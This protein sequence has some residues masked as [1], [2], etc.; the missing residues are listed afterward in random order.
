MGWTKHADAVRYYQKG[1]DQA[2]SDLTSAVRSR[3]RTE[4]QGLKIVSAL[5]QYFICCCVA[6]R[7]N[8]DL[9]DTAVDILFEIFPD[10]EFDFRR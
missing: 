9:C 1:L 7:P 8:E 6:P 10:L 3:R 2:H 4:A 5:D